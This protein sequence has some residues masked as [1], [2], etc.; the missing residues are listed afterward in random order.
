[1]SVGSM[2]AIALVLVSLAVVDARMLPAAPWV[3]SILLSLACAATGIVSWLILG[4]LLLPDVTEPLFL[5]VAVLGGVGSYLA[6]IAVRAAGG[7]VVVTL[8]FG[9]LWSLLVYVPTAI[10]TF[11]SFVPSWSLGILPIDHGGSLPVNVAAGAA[12]LGV[13]LC[14][15]SR[16]KTATISRTTGLLGVIG[17]CSGWIVWLAGAEFAVDE[18]SPSILGNG[19]VGAVGGMVGW[20]VVQRIR[21]RSVTLNSVAAGLICGLV[22]VTA[23]APLFTPVSAAASGILAGAAACVFTLARVGKSRR[24]QWY[25]VGTHLIAGAVGVVLLGLLA[26]NMGFVFTGS[27]AL[28]QDQ[29]VGTLIVAAYSTAVSVGLW[30]ALRSLAGVVKR[31]GVAS[32]A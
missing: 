3:R 19:V 16:V 12:A 1:M 23:G 8:V 11:S 26:T 7:G 15:G 27:V 20:L 9:L 24:Q 29:V 13:L 2:L 5:P 10:R 25:V 31:R 28:I 17:L 32:P 30:L 4:S 21:H 14:G 6:T 22:A 18:V